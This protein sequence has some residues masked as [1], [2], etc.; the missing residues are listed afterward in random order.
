[1]F[2]EDLEDGAERSASPLSSN[3]TLRM[4]LF[5]FERFDDSGTNVSIEACQ[6]RRWQG[7][8]NS[9][10]LAKRK[11][12]QMAVLGATYA[13]SRSPLCRDSR[14]FISPIWKGSKG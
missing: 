6:Y 8:F 14:P 10:C 4:F 1:M 5:A 2:S 3:L 7:Q 11:F 13:L 12:A 9:R